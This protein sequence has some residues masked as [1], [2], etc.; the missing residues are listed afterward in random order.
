MT[1]KTRCRQRQ[2]TSV[3]TRR[4]CAL[5]GRRTLAQ[6]THARRRRGR[7]GAMPPSA[8]PNIVQRYGPHYLVGELLRQGPA[9]MNWRPVVAWP[10][11]PTGGCGAASAAQCELA[12]IPNAPPETVA[13]PRSASAAA[14]ITTNFPQGHER[15][16]AFAVYSAMAGRRT[17]EEAGEKKMSAA[18]LDEQRQL[19]FGQRPVPTPG[20]AR[21]S[22]RAGSS[23]R[24]VRRRRR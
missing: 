24:T 22:R 20:P 3:R 15:N 6:G 19:V 2:G 11:P 4:H 1:A 18:L 14:M 9:H 21:S 13:V 17:G 23:V 12:S 10:G 16:R 8:V 7:W 5:D